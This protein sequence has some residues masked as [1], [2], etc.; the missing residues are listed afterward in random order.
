MLPRLQIQ[1]SLSGN[2]KRGKL[3][4]VPFGAYCYVLIS[5]ALA[6]ES[7]SRQTC[8][9]CNETYGYLKSQL[10]SITAPLPIPNCNA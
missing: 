3:N 8:G 9:Q 10:Q 2:E 1:R 7:V 6:I 4:H 5:L